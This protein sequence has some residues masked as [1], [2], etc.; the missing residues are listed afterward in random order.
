[1][2]ICKGFLGK[3]QEVQEVQYGRLLPSNGIHLYY[4]TVLHSPQPLTVWERDHSLCIRGNSPYS[5][6]RVTVITTVV[7]S[8]QDPDRR[9]AS[10]SLE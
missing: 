8:S 6:L 10:K 3:F 7:R 9:P 5:T 1:M 4:C 2:G